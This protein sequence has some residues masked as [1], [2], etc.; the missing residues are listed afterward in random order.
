MLNL[1]FIV[2]FLDKNNT[3]DGERLRKK[4]SKRNFSSRKGKK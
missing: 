3:Q 4:R 2:A 1:S